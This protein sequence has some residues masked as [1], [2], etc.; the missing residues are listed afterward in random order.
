MYSVINYTDGERIDLDDF[1]ARDPHK[2]VKPT[3]QVCS[4]VTS[5]LTAINYSS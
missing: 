4:T 3:G 2:A 5:N 1:V